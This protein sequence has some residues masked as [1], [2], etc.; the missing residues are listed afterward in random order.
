[1][2]TVIAIVVKNGEVV[3]YA[4]NEHK[5]PCKREGYPT[6][7]GYELCNECDYP[8]HAE[9]K[10]VQKHSLEMQGGTLYLFGH[11]YACDPCKN[12]MELAGIKLKI[13]Q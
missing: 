12:A 4:T 5:E 2:K 11:T 1:M 10:A 3:S 7:T 8:N 9:Y 13:N 6:G